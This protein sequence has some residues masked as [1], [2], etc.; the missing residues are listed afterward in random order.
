MNALGVAQRMGHVARSDELGSAHAQLEVNPMPLGLRALR[1][2]A[3]RA[4]PRPSG[5]PPAAKY[6]N[7]PPLATSPYSGGYIYMCIFVIFV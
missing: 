6:L 5:V 4:P 3:L 7:M 2:G 1:G